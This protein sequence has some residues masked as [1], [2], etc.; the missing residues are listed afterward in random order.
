MP[1]VC[2]QLREVHSEYTGKLGPN[3]KR[4]EIVLEYLKRHLSKYSVTGSAVR[5]LAFIISINKLDD[6][7]VR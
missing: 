2:F 4:D 6:V 7:K 3:Q 5:S 1:L